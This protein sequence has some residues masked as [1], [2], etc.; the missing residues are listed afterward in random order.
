VIGWTT[1]GASVA[2]IVLLLVFGLLLAGSS[3]PST[4]P[5]P[6]TRSAR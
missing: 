2:P 5:S 6:P 3:A 4:R 1:F